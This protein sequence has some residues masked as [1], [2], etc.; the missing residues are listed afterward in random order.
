MVVELEPQEDAML[1]SRSL[2]CADDTLPTPS[3]LSE[4]F[5]LL[6]AMGALI[7]S[8]AS[9]SGQTDNPSDGSKQADPQAQICDGLKQSDP[10][11]LSLSMAKP[12]SP[13]EG[14]SVAEQ[15]SALQ[16]SS[17]LTGEAVRLPEIT[18]SS[19]ITQ[20]EVLRCKKNT[21]EPV[22]PDDPLPQT[23]QSS[24]PAGNLTGPTVSYIGGEL[25]IHAENVRLRDVLEAIQARAGIAVEFPSEAMDDFVFDHVG[26]APVQDALAQLLYGSGYNYVIQTSSQDPQIV[27]KL[28]LSAQTRVASTSPPRHAGPPKNEQADNQA[29]Y[30]GAGYNTQVAIEP[31]PP[32][33]AASTLIGIPPGFNVQ[34]AATTSGK[35]PGQILDELQKHQLQVL[36]D[37]SPPQ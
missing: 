11:H 26:P 24:E 31:I 32:V 22:R 33:P 5:F 20:E 7:A 13:K 14:P 1:R 23:N 29:L 19:R 12:Q 2:L 17:E 6:V 37:Q 3:I 10:H 34:Q 4:H 18:S 25:T 30:G 21:T 9:V 8:P 27:T 35:T 36:D 15:Q 16:G 28:V